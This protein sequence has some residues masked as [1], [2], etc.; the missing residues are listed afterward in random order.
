MYK[1]PY[2]V[3]LDLCPLFT[4][5]FTMSPDKC[6]LT[7]LLRANK[8]HFD[9]TCFQRN[10]LHNMKTLSFL[11]CQLLKFASLKVCNIW[12]QGHLKLSNVALNWRLKSRWQVSAT[13]LREERYFSFFYFHR[14]WN[15]LQFEDLCCLSMLTRGEEEGAAVSGNWKNWKLSGN[16]EK[17][18]FG[19]GSWSYPHISHDHS[20]IQ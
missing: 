16:W 8:F 18:I 19:T 3:G 1:I 15:N 7:G 2:I 5:T 17:F 14:R 10:I 9:S 11:S 6:V 4:Y 13:T 20:V 12:R